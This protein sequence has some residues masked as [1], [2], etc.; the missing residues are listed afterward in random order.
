MMWVFPLLD[1]LRFL[2]LVKAS[3][4]RLQTALTNMLG[5]RNTKTSVPPAA[6]RLPTDKTLWTIAPSGLGITICAVARNLIL[7]P[8][9]SSFGTIHAKCS[10]VWLILLEKKHLVF[11]SASIWSSW[12]SASSLVPCLITLR[13]LV[14]LSSTSMPSVRTPTRYLLG[15]SVRLFWSQSL[16]H[17]QVLGIGYFGNIPS[18]TLV[19]GPILVLGQRLGIHAFRSWKAFG[20]SLQLDSHSGTI[21][22]NGCV[23]F[24]HTLSKHYKLKCFAYHFCL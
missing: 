17:K 3:T 12:A 16:C 18:L 10:M 9:T 11:C 2:V 21:L 8:T 13:H 23:L 15:H 4:P 22:D 20:S 19:I 5:A 24:F 1:S 14:F 7:I 6:T